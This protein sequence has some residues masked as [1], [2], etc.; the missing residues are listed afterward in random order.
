MGNARERLM[1]DKLMEVD[2]DEFTAF[3]L[4]F[5]ESISPKIYHGVS[6]TPK[7]LAVLEKIFEER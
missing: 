6:L 1:L 2:S 5:L 3:E 7:Q 4:E